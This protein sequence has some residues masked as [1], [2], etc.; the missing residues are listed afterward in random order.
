MLGVDGG[1]QRSQKWRERLREHEFHGEVVQRRNRHLRLL[2]L[3]G[4]IVQVPK[5]ERSPARR[6]EIV[7]VDHPIEG[8]LHVVG[9]ERG[10]VVPLHV[11][12]QMEYPAQPVVG[13]LPRP[14]QK[15]LDLIVQ[16]RG[17]GKAL[18][19]VAEHPRRSGVSGQLEVEREGLGDRRHRE[20]A[21]VLADLIGEHLGVPAQFL[22]NGHR[23]NKAPE[24]RRRGHATAELLYGG[25]GFRFD[26]F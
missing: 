23:R 2:P 20:G 4:L 9:G 16:P 12:A 10:A 18:E 5:L 26:C 15:R 25:L 19:Q 24:R 13:T 22:H 1:A 11:V 6:L 3:A 17:L 8:E 21:T 7:V 14:G